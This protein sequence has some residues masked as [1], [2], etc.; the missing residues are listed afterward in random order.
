VNGD[1]ID[2][3]IDTVVRQ[4]MRTEPPAGLRARVMSQLA[5][6]ERRSGLTMPRLAAAA[7]F[8]VC[9]VVGFVATRDRTAPIA[10][11]VRTVE[12]ASAAAPSPSAVTPAPTAMPPVTAPRRQGPPAA[13]LAAR[14]V[15]RSMLPSDD[16]RIV[17]A[18]SID[19][20]PLAVAIAPLRPMAAITAAP[21]E[22]SLVRIKDIAIHP[23]EMEP[24]HVDPSPST[25][26]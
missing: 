9:L 26:R 19:E 15:N 22:S 8:A 20:S 1:E 25:P 2:D 16:E 3:A 7:A 18:M 17:S 24:V 12:V 4:I 13:M 6:P 5:A 23:L 10:E 21:L 11:P 14:S